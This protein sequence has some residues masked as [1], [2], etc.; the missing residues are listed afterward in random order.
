MGRYDQEELA[1]LLPWPAKE[2]NKYSRGKLVLFA[3]S[4]TYPGAACLAACASQR[5]GAGYT[6]VFTA[7]RSVQA[8][9]VSRPS[10]VVH[11]WEGVYNEELQAMQEKRPCAYV[12]GPGFDVKKKHAASLCYFVLGRAKAPV[13][14]D[15]GALPALNTSAGTTLCKGR[16]PDGFPTVITPHMGEAKR[17]A[18]GCDIP[19]D[20]PAE[21]STMLSLHYGVI[22]V[23]K[24]PVTYVSDGSEVY[25]LSSGTPALAKAGTGDVLAGVIGAFLA[26][27]LDA[28]DAA[29]LGTILHGKAGCLA[30]DALTEICVT[31]EDVIDFLPKAIRSFAR[32]TS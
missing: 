12:V 9:Q 27:G 22:T 1:R 11:S 30:A 8:L 15:G 7:P 25:A 2:G 5:A 28:L 23:L 16:L 24:G 32:P 20:D 19:L 21:L 13:L 6:E 26:Q 3:G 17:L 14:V 18:E 4:S 29:V 10:L 31:A